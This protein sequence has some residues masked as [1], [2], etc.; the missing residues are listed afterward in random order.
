M[1]A[2]NTLLK[3]LLAVIVLGVILVTGTI[4]KNW[5]PM[6]DSPGPLVRVAT[7][8]ST[9]TVET[10]QHAARPEL[11]NRVYAATP[12]ETWDAARMAVE[13]LRWEVVH[14]DPDNLS[15]QAVTYTAL[16]RFEGDVYIQIRDAEPDLSTV[17]FHASS[18]LGRGDFAANTRKLLDFREQLETELMNR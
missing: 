6:L 15:I 2:L 7:Y 16:L 18:R 14:S 4:V 1:D 12:Q 8:L 9:N 3:A 5:P 10:R 11:R 17:Y 13:R